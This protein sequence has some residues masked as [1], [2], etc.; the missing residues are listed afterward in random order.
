[1]LFNNDSLEIQFSDG[2]QLELS[3]CGANYQ[4]IFPPS[5]TMVPEPEQKLLQRCKFATSKT[6][7]KVEA[8]LELRN[9]F[10]S[11]PYIPPSFVSL[12]QEK[13]DLDHRDIEEFHWEAQTNQGELSNVSLQSIDDLAT[14]TAELGV[15]K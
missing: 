10:A 2:S 3:P 15:G 9:L 8:A 12:Y 5:K 1:M 6:R 11:R 7:D 13:A 4:Y 14:F